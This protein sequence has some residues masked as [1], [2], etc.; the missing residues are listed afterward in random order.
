[1]QYYFLGQEKWDITGGSNTTPPTDA[2]ATK[3]WKAK[4]GNAMYILTVTIEDE[5]L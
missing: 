1:M 5:F 2:E 3:R 4:A